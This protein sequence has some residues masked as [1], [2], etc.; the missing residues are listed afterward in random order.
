MCWLL[1]AYGEE[2]VLLPQYREYTN[3]IPWS[4]LQYE[5]IPSDNQLQST[6]MLENFGDVRA[7]LKK[8]SQ[9]IDCIIRL[10]VFFLRLDT[11]SPDQF[12]I[13]HCP[14]SF[15]VAINLSWALYAFS[16]EDAQSPQT[17]EGSNLIPTI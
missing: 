16:Q 3:L 8:L 13:G 11:N 9:T 1:S 7:S 10:T 2:F 6:P 4:L 15:E 5:S 12:R 14:I 17:L